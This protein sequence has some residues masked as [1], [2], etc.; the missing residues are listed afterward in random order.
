MVRQEEMG[1][2]F[3]LSGSADGAV[4][5]CDKTTAG[6]LT[7]APFLRSLALLLLLG[8][9]CLL[10]TFQF[11]LI[12]GLIRYLF[13]KTEINVL[14]LGLDYAGKTVSSATQVPRCGASRRATSSLH[15][16]LKPS[17]SCTMAVRAMYN[18]QRLSTVSTHRA[19]TIALKCFGA[20]CWRHAQAC[21]Y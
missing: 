6:A 9:L 10:S 5:F 4:R 21:S 1:G 15:S 8:S 19:S 12:A 2:I 16:S 7:A 20:W 14:I 18:V 3:L 17:S 13:S 11:S